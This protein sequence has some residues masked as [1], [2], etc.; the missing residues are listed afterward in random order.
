[1]NAHLAREAP[2]AY[3]SHTGDCGGRHALQECGYRQLDWQE[4]LCHLG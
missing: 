4:D 2:Q 1:M 3:S